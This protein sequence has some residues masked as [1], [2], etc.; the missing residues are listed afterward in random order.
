[1]SCSPR[2]PVFIAGRGAM[3]SPGGGEVQMLST[4]NALAALGMVG[5]TA[6]PD[7]AALDGAD[8]VHLFG[9]HPEFVPLARAAR[10][11]RLPVVLSPI[12]W[13]DLASYWRLGGSLPGRLAASAR[14][15][16]RAACPW[17][18][19]WRRRLY[20]A[21]D[22]LLP[23]SQAEARQLTRYFRVPAERIHVVPN[24]AEPR[25][26][27]PSPEPFAQRF[28]LR[29][30]VFCPGR[31]EPRK[32]QLALVRAVRGTELRLVI[33][34]DV[35]PG[36]EPYAA[37]CRREA[38]PEVVFLPRLGRD[39][40]LFMSAYPACGCLALASWFETPGLVAIEAAMSGTPLVLP[41]RGSAHEYFG[42]RAQYVEPGDVRGIRRAL[43]KAVRQPRNP[44][45]ARWVQNH[46]TW[47]AV[48]RATQE[49]Y[50]KA[51]GRAQ[52][53]TS[54]ARHG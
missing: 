3:A 13:F 14:F 17:L 21:A 47:A 28:R 16:A 22:L 35:V 37:G 45:L 2:R 50:R 49:A 18:P 46:Y 4:A 20:R 42:A 12:A 8:V 54:S 6:T 44:D 29:G 1:M 15:A 53:D 5:R 34:G 41:T 36:F 26:A 25:F 31:I 30:F 52:E 51:L 33:L 9:S 19:S 11:K 39:D 10:R 23:N 7:E 43:L 24:G 27:E 38:G 48:A 40:P 32:N